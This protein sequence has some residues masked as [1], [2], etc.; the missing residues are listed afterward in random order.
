MGWIGTRMRSI[1]WCHFQW[2][3]TNLSDLAIFFVY[4]AD[5]TC[6]RRVGTNAYQC[7]TNTTNFVLGD[8]KHQTPISFQCLSRRFLD[9]LT[10][11]ASTTC[12]GNLF[13]ELTTLE[14]KKHCLT[15]VE[16]L[17]LLSFREWPR[18]PFE[19]TMKKWTKSTFYSA[20]VN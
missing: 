4:K 10:D 9:V 18:S 1:E 6:L 19:G 14:L 16:H 2:P 17:C 7:T 5:G 15:V 11:G 13:Q 20:T 3:W 12:S 8:D